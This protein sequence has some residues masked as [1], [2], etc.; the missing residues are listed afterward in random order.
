MRPA[1]PDPV[2]FRVAGPLPKAV[3]L[4]RTPFFWTEAAMQMKLV[5]HDGVYTYDTQAES[6]S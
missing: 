1:S 2:S 3:L 4:S 5:F 6:T